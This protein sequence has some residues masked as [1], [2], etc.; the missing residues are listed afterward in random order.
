MTDS[1][2]AGSVVENPPA[3]NPAQPPPT[4]DNGSAAE[5]DKSWFDGLSEGNRKLA[6][7]KGWTTPESL[8]KAFTSFAELERKIGDSL[9]VPAADAPKEDWDK[10]YSKLPETMR[11]VESADKID[12]K[13]PDGLPEN[14]PYSEEMA[15]ASKQWMADAKLSPTQAQA[16]HDRFAGYMAEQ[17]TAQQA[18]IA[19]SVEETHESLVKDWGPTDSDGFKQK[20]ELANRAMKKLDL[21]E[22]YKQKGILLPDGALTDARIAKAFQAIGET[23]FKE[24]DLPDGGSFGV[25][26]PFKKDANGNRNIM[27]ISALVAKDP[28]RAERLAREAGEDPRKWISNNPY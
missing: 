4:V 15:A 16:M 1:A 23:M 22:T 3:G 21:V 19:Q 7:T 28:P 20:L 12:F 9:R 25:E 26:N 17:A 8:D 11:P 5:G 13:R 24:D 18:A 2:D 6:E 14:L 27:A 10:F